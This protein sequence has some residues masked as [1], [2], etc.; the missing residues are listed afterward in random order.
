M[1]DY[2]ASA[3]ARRIEGAMVRSVVRDESVARFRAR[4]PADALAVM[5]AYGGGNAAIGAWTG[6]V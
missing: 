6:R 2:V 1:A 4:Y 3:H 5:F